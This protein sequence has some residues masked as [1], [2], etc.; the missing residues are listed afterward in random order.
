MRLSYRQKEE[1]RPIPGYSEFYSISA[2]GRLYSHRRRCFLQGVITKNPRGCTSY[3][4]YTLSVG[5]QPVR[6]SAH[7]L[8][9]SAF[10]GQIPKGFV[11]NHKDGNGLNNT[12]ANLE[13]VTQQANC[14]HAW[15]IH[16]DTETVES[17]FADFRAGY[18]RADI[19]YRNGISEETVDDWLA[20]KRPASLPLVGTALGERPSRVLGTSLPPEQEQEAA[21]LYATGRY[22][23]RTLVEMFGVDRATIRKIIRRY[24]VALRPQ[25]NETAG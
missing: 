20:R 23:Q 12:V 1:M 9:A 21:R 7:R 2:S 4:Y 17:V 25:E 6:V 13:I 8:V 3:H 16:E 10:I 14:I 11:V 19:A 24:D 5:R 15:Q 22:R 18:C